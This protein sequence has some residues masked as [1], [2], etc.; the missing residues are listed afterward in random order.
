MTSSA[1]E[2]FNDVEDLP[3]PAAIISPMTNT[4]LYVRSGV[5]TH[6]VTYCHASILLSRPVGDGAWESTYFHCTHQHAEREVAE[7]CAARAER[8]AERNNGKLPAGWVEGV[9]P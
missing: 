5:N 6:V 1:G 2:I 7:Q 9:R 4:S 3:T 8:S